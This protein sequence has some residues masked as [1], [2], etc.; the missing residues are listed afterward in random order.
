MIAPSVMGLS[1]SPDITTRYL[2]LLE[3]EISDRLRDWISE[4]NP[5]Q[6]SHPE[7]LTD[8][9]IIKRSPSVT[10]PEHLT[11]TFRPHAERVLRQV[12]NSK[13]SLIRSSYRASKIMTRLWKHH[14]AQE[15]SNWDSSAMS[16]SSIRH[17]SVGALNKRGAI[18]PFKS[19]LYLSLVPLG[20]MSLLLLAASVRVVQLA[21]EK[22]RQSNLG[23]PH[24]PKPRL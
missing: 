22:L 7:V 16:S 13:D 11:T 18:L 5:Q 14:L 3:S 12:F 1:Y 21:P 20:L 19:A 23:V 9:A 8:N 10:L 17:P 2:N 4:E 24:L 15:L 6:S